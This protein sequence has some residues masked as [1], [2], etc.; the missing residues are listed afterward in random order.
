MY[1]DDDKCKQENKEKTVNMKGCLVFGRWTSRQDASVS[2][3]RGSSPYSTS[4]NAEI[5]VAF[6]MFYVIQTQNTDTRHTS[7]SMSTGSVW[8][9]SL[10][11]CFPLSVAQTPQSCQKNKQTNKQTTTT[12]TTKTKQNKNNNNNNNNKQTN[13][14]IRGKQGKRETEETETENENC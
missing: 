5:E 9:V 1:Y 12:T 8:V 7:P 11:P 14:Q 4:Y 2:Q 6:Q 13:K 3:R 10:F